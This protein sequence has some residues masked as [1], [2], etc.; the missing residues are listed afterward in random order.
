M[1][2]WVSPFWR[3]WEHFTLSP[4]MEQLCLLSCLPEYLVC[5]EVFL[6]VWSEGKLSC[7]EGHLTQRNSLMSRIVCRN[8]TPGSILAFPVLFSFCLIFFVYLSWIQLCLAVEYA[9]FWNM[10]EYIKVDWKCGVSAMRHGSLKLATLW[11]TSAATS[12]HIGKSTIFKTRK[13]LCLAKEM[14]PMN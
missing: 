14:R 8:L 3:S 9:S 1:L 5:N 6:S 7:H 13:S 12:S 2:Q 4:E 10:A 11:S